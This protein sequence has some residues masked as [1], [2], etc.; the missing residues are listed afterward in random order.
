MIVDKEVITK[1]EFY[2]ERIKNAQ[3]D[4]QIVNF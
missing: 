3:K 1:C 4:T 2:R